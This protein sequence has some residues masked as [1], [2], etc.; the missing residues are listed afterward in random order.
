MTGSHKTLQQYLQI[1]DDLHH[2]KHSFCSFLAYG[3]QSQFHM[4][5]ALIVLQCLVV[6]PDL[7]IT[8]N[9]RHHMMLVN[10]RHIHAPGYGR[11]EVQ[12]C[13]PS[14]QIT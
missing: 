7:Q 3:V 11:R 10:P 8:T 12:G 6:D 4:L 2:V 14:F 9:G 1:Y 5:H 13:N